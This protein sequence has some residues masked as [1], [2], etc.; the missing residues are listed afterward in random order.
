MD[1]RGRRNTWTGNELVFPSRKLLGDVPLNRRT[2]FLL[3]HSRIKPSFRNLLLVLP[4]DKEHKDMR[5][6]FTSDNSWFYFT[7][8]FFFLFFFFFSELGTEPRALRLLGKRSTTELNPQ[9][10]FTSSFHW[11]KVRIDSSGGGLDFKSQKSE[12]SV[13]LRRKTFLSVMWPNLE[14]GTVG[15]MW[16]PSLLLFPSHHGSGC[17]S[18][19]LPMI[20]QDTHQRFT[21]CIVSE[22]RGAEEKGVSAPSEISKMTQQLPVRLPGHL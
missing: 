7:S 11:F 6:K 8:S 4:F 19:M 21:Y 16:N 1:P 20:Q 17:E 9:P 13:V 10:H 14:V 22:E 3:F 5:S 15:V 18:L 12:I 2:T